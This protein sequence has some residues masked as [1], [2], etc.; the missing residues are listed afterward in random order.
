M[1]YENC[2]M[3]IRDAATYAQNCL[4]MCF[5]PMFIN[6]I[7]EIQFIGYLTLIRSRFSIINFLLTNY[8]KNNW[9]SMVDENHDLE[10][11]ILSNS[12]ERKKTD[13]TNFLINIWRKSN[14][15]TM[16]MKKGKAAD[17]GFVYNSDNLIVVQ[18]ICNKLKIALNLIP[19]AF[20]VQT[21]LLLVVQ[22]TTMTSLGY[23]IC[24]QIAK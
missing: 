8:D 2:L 9:K 12:I 23:D 1:E 24:M 21:I 19:N 3:Y 6:A 16:S 17:E 15:N 20:G 11:V 13:K 7:S 4:I 5:I 14:Q 18:D 10:N 22:F